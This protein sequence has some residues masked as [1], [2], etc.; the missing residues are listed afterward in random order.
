MLS[1]FLFSTILFTSCLKTEHYIRIQ[2]LY[3]EAFSEVSVNGSSYGRI[4]SGQTSTYRQIDEGN[5]SISGTT[6]SGRILSGSGSITG[7]GTHN[8]TITISSTGTV[9]ISENK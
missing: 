2:N 8:W 3:T 5:I 6:M 9:G 4:E 7:K 1:L